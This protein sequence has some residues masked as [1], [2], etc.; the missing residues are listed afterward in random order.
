ME[1]WPKGIKRAG[2]DG[3]E[4]LIFLK[5]VYGK[6]LVVDEYTQKYYPTDMK[7]LNRLMKKNKRDDC[8]LVFTTKA[9]IWR[10]YKDFWPKKWLKRFLGRYP[11]T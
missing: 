1:Y 7:G 3:N 10:Q 4:M 9:N 11:L 5:S 2:L 6:M 8:S